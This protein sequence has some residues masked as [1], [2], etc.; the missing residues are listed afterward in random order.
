MPAVAAV[1]QDRLGPAG[2][3]SQP[4]GTL[5]GNRFEAAHGGQALLAGDVD[6]V[7]MDAASSRGYIGA[8]P[9]KLKVVGDA[10]GTDNYGFIF[11]LGSDL[12][13]PFNAAIA[14]LK[15]DGTLDKLT[16]KWF[17]EYNAK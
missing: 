13:G 11:R 2:I 4:V 17:Y 3:L 16:T 6:T 12:V 7:L 9:D 14:A 1:G 8:N 10:L 15:A 5:A